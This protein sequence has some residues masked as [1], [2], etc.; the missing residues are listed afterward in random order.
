[1]SSGQLIPQRTQVNSLG[2]GLTARSSLTRPKTSSTLSPKT[3]SFAQNEALKVEGRSRNPIRGLSS[4]NAADKSSISA[5]DI[6]IDTS[7]ASRSSVGL[8]DSCDLIPSPVK[9]HIPA[10]GPSLLQQ[11]AEVARRRILAAVCIQRWY[12][13][14]IRN[15]I[16]VRER[17]VKDLLKNRKL[18]LHAQALQEQQRS[19][20]VPTPADAEKLSADAIFR[21]RHEREVKVRQARSDVYD[22]LSPPKRIQDLEKQQ[23][24]QHVAAALRREVYGEV[25]SSTVVAAPHAQV[26]DSSRNK[27]LEAVAVLQAV[28][29]RLFV[30]RLSASNALSPAHLDRS[31]R[32]SS[33]ISHSHA[34]SPSPRAQPHPSPHRV[35]HVVN[36]SSVHSQAP[37]ISP[38]KNLSFSSPVASGTQSRTDLS[39]A[40][41]L[42]WA[43]VDSPVS[44][45]QS[46]PTLAIKSAK[47]DSFL[48][49]LDGVDRDIDDLNSKSVLSSSSKGDLFSDH[50]NELSLPYTPVSHIFSQPSSH[51][52]ASARSVASAASTVGH[53]GASAIYSDVKIKFAQMR[54]EIDEKTK[55]NFSLKHAL[56]DERAQRANCTLEFNRQLAELCATKDREKEAALQRQLEFSDKLMRDKTELAD[57]IESLGQQFI[58]LKAEHERQLKQYKERLQVDMDKAVQHAV[59]KERSRM[60]DAQEAAQQRFQETTM[61][62]YSKKL[63]R[64]QA[65]HNQELRAQRERFEDDLR[66][67]KDETRHE[68]QQTSEELRVR[69]LQEREAALEQERETCVRRLRDMSERCEAQMQSLRVKHSQELAEERERAIVQQRADRQRENDMA[70][71]RDEETLRET[72]QIRRDHDLAISS[73]N[74]QHEAEILEFKRQ[75][76]KLFVTMQFQESLTLFPDQGHQGEHG[77]RAQTPIQRRIESF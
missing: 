24:I 71:R 42:A 72:K 48:H 68:R 65:T 38:R 7:L 26:V 58:V 31:Q 37:D 6:D 8:D 22:I 66:A 62:G 41:P 2:Q 20:S 34:N 1:M 17:E 43:P 60:I 69:M 76:Q 28:V 49:F 44:R 36:D 25:D 67:L 30:S 32:F 50:N 70:Q 53:A 45:S 21:R 19:R 52:S 40:S 12:R 47:A 64:M 56:E 51:V 15:L 46:V 61:I 3:S 10:T 57:R 27:R 13:R 77:A 29:S 55:L 33:L 9:Q 74:R 35:N 59:S 4:A 39:R 14:I 73:L 11:R 63:E 54:V 23:R 5:S 75:V 16:N 18:Q